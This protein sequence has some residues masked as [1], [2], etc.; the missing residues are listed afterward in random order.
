[1]AIKDIEYVTIEVD[2]KPVSLRKDKP[3]L[4]GL[5]DQ[6][7]DIPYFCAHKWLDPL[8][9]CR[10]CMVKVSWNGKPMPKLQ[11]S[12][13][14]TP[15]EGMSVETRVDE[16]LTARREQLEFHLI[17]HPLECP[18]CDKGGE[19]ML[20]DQTYEHGC[21]EGR[22]TENKKVRSDRQMNAYIQINYKRCIHCKR[23]VGFTDEID[24]S[25]LLKM[26]SRGAESWIESYPTS[27]DL[28]YFSGNVIDICPVGALTA[29]NYRFTMGRPWEQ[30]LTASVAS[31][32]STGTNIWLNG[33]L[34]HVARIIPRENEAVDV[35]MLDDATRFSWESIDDPSRLR[36]ALVHDNGETR[37]VKLA[38][39]QELLAEKLSAIL[40]EHP[41]DSVGVIAGGNRTTEEYMS[42]RHFATRVLDTRWYA[43]GEDLAGPEGMSEMVLDALLSGATSI[44]HILAASTILTIGTDLWEEAPVLGLR[45]NVEVRKRHRRLVNLRSH[46]SKADDFATYIDYG[47]GNLLRTVRSATNA[48]LGSGA[49]TPEGDRLA[50]S[51][52]Q[53]GDDCAILYGSEVWRDPQAREVIVAIQDLRD[54]IRRA[55]P[56][57]AVYSNAVYPSANSAGALLAGWFTKFGR[58]GSGKESCGGIGKVLKAAADGQLKALFICD[59][60]AL[61]R[62][63]D[64]QL[65]EKALKATGLTVYAGSFGNPT[66]THCSFHLPLG[67]WAHFDGTVV[68]LEWRVQKRRRGQIDSVA[69]SLS[70]LVNGISGD[71]QRGFLGTTEDMYSQLRHNLEFWPR[72]EFGKFPYKGVLVTPRAKLN[73]NR[74]AVSELPAEYGAGARELVVIPKSFLYNDR[75]LLA[76]SPVFGKVAMPFHAFMNPADMQAQGISD[77]DTVA[78]GGITLTAKERDWVRSGSV[79]VND[80]C[81]TAPANSAGGPGFTSAGIK[82]ASLAGSG[83]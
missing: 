49:R 78:I 47:Y 7:F 20:Q 11:I 41:S 63:P 10:M 40:E 33:R 73:A 54:A 8:G 23:C 9:A 39:A 15:A 82:K 59:Y 17:N 18:V 30:E 19:C 52:R 56:D 3:I 80:F 69:P 76:N 43:F 75:D 42:L 14:I 48:L 16:V 66:S 58:P 53:V 51:L 50:D 65:V 68:S 83:A 32:D 31:L 72:D 1:M 24:N 44:E 60:D 5:R 22:Y 4:W 67:T 70:E 26:V 77:G 36:K 64:R 45:A 38:M 62:Y 12:C 21:G 46:G 37:S 74:S 81:H 28:P 29:T 25:H 27:D 13:A 61:S 71:M 6:G 57:C 55:N 34:G 2:G 79:V 35:G